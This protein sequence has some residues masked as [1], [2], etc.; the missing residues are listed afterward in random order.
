MKI[1]KILTTLLCAGTAQ[2]A[3]PW[4]VTDSRDYNGLDLFGSDTVVGGMSSRV[5]ATAVGSNHQILLANAFTLYGDLVSGGSISPLDQGSFNQSIYGTAWSTQI[6]APYAWAVAPAQKDVGEWINRSD[7]YLGNNG[8]GSLDLQVPDFQTLELAPGR[9]GTITMGPGSKIKLRSGKYILK[10]FSSTTSIEGG[11]SND[12]EII[13]DVSGGDIQVDVFEKLFFAGNTR[14]SFDGPLL[15][16]R[17]HWNT[18]QS[19]QLDLVQDAAYFYGNIG[20]PKAKVSFNNSVN[21]IGNVRARALDLGYYSKVCSPPTLNSLWHTSGQL[22]PEFDPIQND[23]RAVLGHA[24]EADTLHAS[25]GNGIR[26]NYPDGQVATTEGT[27][28]IQLFDPARE[29]FMPG[30]GSSEYRV[31]LSQSNDYAL[32]VKDASWSCPSGIVCDGSSWE[33]A[34][35]GLNSAL[36]HSSEGKEFW[37][38]EGNYSLPLGLRLNN[39]KLSGG[40]EGTESNPNSRQ[41]HP[42]YTVLDGKGTASHLLRASNHVSLDNL[43]LTGVNSG[44][45]MGGAINMTRG[46]FDLEQSIIDANQGNGTGIA[47]YGMENSEAIMKRN[48]LSKNTLLAGSASI[49]GLGAGAL[50]YGENLALTE[51]ELNSGTLISSETDASSQLVHNSIIANTGGNSIFSGGN[52]SLINTIVWQPG[53]ALS[54]SGTTTSAS[55]SLAHTA[56][57]GT[58]NLNIGPQLSSLNSYGEDG[59]P[60]TP[61]DGLVPDSSLQLAVNQNNIV[62]SSDL[63]TI[64]RPLNSKITIGAREIPFGDRVYIATLP[65]TIFFKMQKFYSIVPSLPLGDYGDY[66]W[67]EAG[68]VIVKSI[69]NN[70]HIKNPE[71]IKYALIEIKIFNNNNQLCPNKS[72]KLKMYPNQI[73]NEKI[74]FSTL[75]LINSVKGKPIIFTSN[76]DCN[77]MGENENGILLPGINNGSLS[78]RITYS[79]SSLVY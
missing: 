53:V 28:R 17:V 30:C 45:S 8:Y 52:A 12:A 13:Y 47:Y 18:W 51:N 32:R 24:I 25:A 69:P 62:I 60:F 33:R 36:L 70:S 48:Y 42:Y 10:A 31:S 19:S 57:N 20:A 40:F 67:G 49:I 71:K 22:G 66:Y 14:A 76:K 72:F 23:Y 73:S 5:Y 77:L 27:Y 44:P 54:S 58:G 65:E 50:F 75:S 41:G 34:L 26:I 11:S 46:R 1:S 15:P 9:Y 56:L 6:T 29:A 64:N 39:I 16:S 59:I 3:N 79:A 2:A 63:L 35:P 21:F 78:I 61:D 74:E 7:F 55:Y 68:R 4:Q 43:R 37:L 38:A